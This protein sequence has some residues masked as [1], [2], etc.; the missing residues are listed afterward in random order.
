MDDGVEFFV[1]SMSLL[2]VSERCQDEESKFLVL[3]LAFAENEMVFVH[4]SVFLFALI[5]P[6]HSLGGGAGSFSILKD[7]HTALR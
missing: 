1:G 2:A 4:L 5:C 3:V 7:S 6:Q